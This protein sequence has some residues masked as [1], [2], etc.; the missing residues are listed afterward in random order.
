[1]NSLIHKHRFVLFVLLAIIVDFIPFLKL[2]FVLSET[3][4]HEISHG[5]AAVLTGGSIKSISLN[6]NGS[7]L[8]VSQGGIRFVVIFAGYFGAAFWG[9]L[10]YLSAD[11]MKPRVAHIIMG[12]YITILLLTMI[13]WAK[14]I[15]T[16]I[17][18]GTMVGLFAFFFKSADS[19]LLKYILQFIGIFI[20]LNAIRSPL[21]LIDGQNLGD[22][23]SLSALTFVPEMVWISIWFFIG[24]GCLYVLY[25]ASYKD[26]K[27][28]QLH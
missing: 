12:L 3:F 22:G 23:A 1:M 19:M 9:M 27:K 10:I 28:H 5:L 21:V 26:I 15:P 24:L 18:L 2:P 14:G 11:N 13:L 17:I 25:K 7:G 16:Y 4:F 8:C 20:L 6:Y